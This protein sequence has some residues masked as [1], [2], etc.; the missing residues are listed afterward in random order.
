MLGDGLWGFYQIRAGFVAIKDSCVGGLANL[1]QT[2]MPG[3]L[4]ETLY[5]LSSKW[6]LT[7]GAQDVLLR[8]GF[9]EV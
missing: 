8:R 4:S 7:G 5:Q 1:R 2:G 9:T 6:Q 3:C